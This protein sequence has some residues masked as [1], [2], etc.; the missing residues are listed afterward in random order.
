MRQIRTSRQT[1]GRTDGTER[2]VDEAEARSS[3]ERDDVDDPLWRQCVMS[4]RENEP[5]PP[6]FST[7]PLDEWEP[8]TEPSAKSTTEPTT[9]S[10]TESN[11]TKKSTKRSVLLQKYAGRALILTE[12]GCGIHCRFCF[13][14]HQQKTLTESVDNSVVNDPIDD[15]SKTVESNVIHS[16][17]M[18][19]DVS[20]RRRFV[21]AAAAIRADENCTEVILSGGDPLMQSDTLLA[22]QYTTI[23]AI[24]HVKR[25]R[26]HTRIPIVLPTRITDELCRILVG[27]RLRTVVVLHVNHPNE[28]DPT[29]GD[30][31]LTAIRRL[32]TAGIPLL[33]QTT[34]LRGVNNSVETLATLMEMLVDHRVIPYYLHQLDRVVGAAHFEVPVSEGRRIMEALRRRLPGYAVPRYVREIAGKPYKIPLE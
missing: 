17:E 8:T 24:P 26:I 31:P 4:P 22:W 19:S 32:A 12:S 29:L 34:L 23:A 27:S 16:H 2:C 3:G 18:D 13:R 15:D 30:E 21:D 10:T 6:D 11:R 25:M 1:S 9:E 33:S 20:F 7:D 5:S 14:R 28:I